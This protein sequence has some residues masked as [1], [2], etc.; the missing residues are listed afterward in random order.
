MRATGTARW[1]RSGLSARVP[2]GGVRRA[3]RAQLVGSAGATQF[4]YDKDGKLR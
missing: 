1:R 3:D 4:G 2:T